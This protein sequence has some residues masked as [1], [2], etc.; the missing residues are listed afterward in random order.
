MLLTTMD[1]NKEPG[2]NYCY[3]AINSLTP[4]TSER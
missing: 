4:A 1:I 2:V 3:L